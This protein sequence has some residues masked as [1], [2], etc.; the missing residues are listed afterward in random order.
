MSSQKNDY[1]YGYKAVYYYKRLY[2][3]RGFEQLFDEDKIV[4]IGKAIIK[5]KIPKS[6]NPNN[7]ARTN[8]CRKKYAQFRCTRA[9]VVEIL[10]LETK[11]HVSQA[12]SILDD[13]FIYNVGCMVRVENF[14]NKLEKVNSTG[15]HFFLEKQLA[16]EYLLKGLGNGKHKI[17]NKNGELKEEYVVKNGKRHGFYK[18][19]KHEKLNVICEYKD[20]KKHGKYI[21][22]H[23]DQVQKHNQCFYKNDQKHGIYK[24]W[25]ENGDLNISCMYQNGKKHGLYQEWYDIGGLYI[26]CMYQ[27]GKKHGLYQEWYDNGGLY[28]S[29]MYQNGKKHGLYQKWY[30]NMV[31][32]LWGWEPI[33]N[34]FWRE[35]CE[36]KN[37]KR[38][39][40]YKKYNSKNELKEE[41]EYKNNKRNGYYKK[42]NSNSN[43]LEKE[44]EY[45][46]D[47]RNGNYKEYHSNGLIEEYEYKD[48]KRHGNYKKYN[49]N[50]LKEECEYKDDKRDGI[51]KKYSKGLLKSQFKYKKGKLHGICYIYHEYSKMKH[52]TNEKGQEITNKG[53]IRQPL[54]GDCVICMEE[55]KGDEIG[56][57]WK[58]CGTNFHEKCLTEWYLSVRDINATCPLCRVPLPNNYQR[59]YENGEL[60]FE[61]RYFN[62]IIPNDIF[63]I[64]DE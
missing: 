5:L 9:Y 64:N 13:E 36:Y 24:Q 44:C 56:W 22:Y 3:N 31:G 30:D 17:Y 15:I 14:D 4:G 32:L 39:G 7:L 43:R 10:D 45:K 18:K 41:C 60:I 11:K 48:D 58:R 35:E 50:R 59:K 8:V 19:Y 63:S 51:R 6:K 20:G 28:L 37:N 12:F 42:Y 27:N 34:D 40:Y 2:I 49:S 61:K 38:N 25:N 47:K 26:S 21:K 55:L 52:I 29:C 1:I 23:C 33:Y 62:R 53:I 16:R 57:C 46:N 54:E